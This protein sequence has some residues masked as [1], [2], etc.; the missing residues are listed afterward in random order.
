MAAGCQHARGA[1]LAAIGVEPE[2]SSKLGGAAKAGVVA[3]QLACPGWNT[4]M[5]TALGRYNCQ[6]MHQL[7]CELLLVLLNRGGRACQ[8]RK[9]T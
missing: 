1:S 5:Q 9:S 8:I 2:R 7:V 3:G 6:C 4:R